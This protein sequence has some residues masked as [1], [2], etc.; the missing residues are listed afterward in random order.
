M[1]ER[2][3]R[4]DPIGI[5]LSGNK[6]E[7]LFGGA[8]VGFTVRRE[9][10]RNDGKLQEGMFLVFADETLEIL[11]VKSES[12]GTRLSIFQRPSVGENLSFFLQESSGLPLIKAFNDSQELLAI[13]E[14]LE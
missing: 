9:M 12:K 4:K 7:N 8:K 11:D 5:W 1:V 3:N 14:Y 6:K 13:I 10:T 2:D